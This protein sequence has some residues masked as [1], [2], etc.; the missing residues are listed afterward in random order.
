MKDAGVIKDRSAGD[1]LNKIQSY[2]RSCKVAA[3]FAN[4][5]GEGIRETDGEASFHQLVQKRFKHCFF[6][7]PIMRDRSNIKPAASSDDFL[8]EDL[9]SDIGSVGGVEDV[10]QEVDNFLST[11]D[12][13]AS[14]QAT[15][16]DLEDNFH[17]PKKI[18]KLWT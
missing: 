1:I 5:T 2:E 3:D 18:L 9:I 11:I 13:A 17:T 10:T 16:P 8:N 4:N 12:Y 14:S 6:L 7:E 15:A